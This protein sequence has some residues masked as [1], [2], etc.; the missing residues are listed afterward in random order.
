MFGPLPL[1]LINGKVVG[2]GFFNFSRYKPGLQ[3]CDE[4]DSSVD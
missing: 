1:A 2:R 3:D 4:P